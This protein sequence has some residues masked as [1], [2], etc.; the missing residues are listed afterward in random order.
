MTPLRFDRFELLPAERQLLRDGQALPIGGRAFDLLCALVMLRHRVV[1]HDELLE[2]V[3]PG[4]AVEA[5]N[6]QVQVWALRKLLGHRA[7]ATVARRGYRFMLHPIESPGAALPRRADPV[8]LQA[9]MALMAQLAGHRWI[10]LV[11][12]PGLGSLQLAIACAR[13]LAEANGGLVWQADAA[14][15]AAG[16]AQ[17]ADPSSAVDDL[18]RPLAHRPG[19]LVLGGLHRPRPGM[20]A[21]VGLLHD[22]APGLHLLALAPGALGH[23]AERVLKLPS[24]PAVRSGLA[25]GAAEPVLRW[26]ARSR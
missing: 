12:P 9:L 11:G 18:L 5:N 8:E 21:R 3:W 10:T 26:R 15:L 23:A 17:P 16:D 20:A 24:R 6:L 19:V 4:L 2:L 22:R 7:I 25:A 1:S 14:A 13:R